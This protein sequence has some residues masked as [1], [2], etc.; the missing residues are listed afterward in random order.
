V[1]TGRDAYLYIVAILGRALLEEVST[2]ERHLYV[3]HLAFGGDRTLPVDGYGAV[4]LVL[5]GD[6][7]EGCE[8]LVGRHVVVVPQGLELIGHP[9]GRRS[10]RGRHTLTSELR[11]D[12]GQVRHFTSARRGVRE[13]AGS[14]RPRLVR[15]AGVGWLP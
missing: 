4:P 13:S 9:S 6:L 2:H 12:Q 11:I 3:Q 7:V 1:T 14:R 10:S 15:G 5:L 8:L